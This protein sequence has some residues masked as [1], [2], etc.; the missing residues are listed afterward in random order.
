MRGLIR[1]A[2]SWDSRSGSIVLRGKGIARRKAAALRSELPLR[3]CSKDQPYLSGENCR[4]IARVDKMK[5]F[6]FIF[7]NLEFFYLP[8][9]KLFEGRPHSGTPPRSRRFLHDGMIG[10]AA[11]A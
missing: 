2:G 11:I 7:S 1:G 4:H 6:L 8:K 3:H 5:I 9:I 10:I